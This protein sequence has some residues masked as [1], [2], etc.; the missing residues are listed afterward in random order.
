MQY[1]RALRLI[2]PDY[3]ILLMGIGLIVYFA[4]R[5]FHQSQTSLQRPTSSSDLYKD[6]LPKQVPKEVKKRCR[7]QAPHS[8]SSLTNECFISHRD[9][10]FAQATGIHRHENDLSDC[11]RELCQSPHLPH[12]DNYLRKTLG[13]DQLQDKTWKTWAIQNLFVFINIM[14]TGIA[15]IISPSILNSI[16][17]LSFLGI[18]TFWACGNKVTTIHFAYMRI[19]LLVYS[20]IHVCLIYLVQLQFAQQFLPDGQFISRYIS[21]LYSC[22]R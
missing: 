16:Y 10:S 20:A 7:N 13:I 22:S 8:F 15:G 2:L 9:G 5:R 14:V 1:Q 17:L 4:K 21:C 12:G 19:F 3:V 18:C 6:V 11:D